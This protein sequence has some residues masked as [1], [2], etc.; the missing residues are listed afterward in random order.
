MVVNGLTRPQACGKWFIL[1][2]ETSVAI[3][4]LFVWWIGNL[5]AKMRMGGVDDGV[6]AVR[7]KQSYA[8]AGDEALTFSGLAS[9]NTV[10]MHEVR[11]KVGYMME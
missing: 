5:R 10:T 8:E 6:G 3:S 2:V 11:Q 9:P 1:P 4:V 7:Q